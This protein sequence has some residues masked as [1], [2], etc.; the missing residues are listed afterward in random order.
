M[1]VGSLFLKGKASC[2]KAFNTCRKHTSGCLSWCVLFPLLH[3]GQP[4]VVIS[5]FFSYPKCSFP[6]LDAFR[7]NGKIFCPVLCIV[8]SSEMPPPDGEKE[9]SLLAC[10]CQPTLSSSWQCCL[11]QR[12]FIQ[13]EK[14]C[15]QWERSLQKD[16][17]EHRGSID[18]PATGQSADYNVV[19]PQ[20]YSLLL[21][22]L[23]QLVQVHICTC[24]S[25]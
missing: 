12:L 19:M 22:P 7:H 8:I 15:Y 23:P 2:F 16:T 1:P 17:S 13:E 3:C 20:L 21:F 24:D 18:P 10:D 5:L 9:S 14:W 4:H 11:V 6:A 25:V